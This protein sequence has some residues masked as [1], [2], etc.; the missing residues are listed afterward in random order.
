MSL[1]EKLRLGFLARSRREKL[2]TVLFLVV[3]AALWLV[4]F[5]DRAQAFGPKLAQVN[6]TAANQSTVLDD[7]ERIETKYETAV[8]TLSATDRPSGS[9]AY[10]TVDQIVRSSGFSDFNI[11]PPQPQRRDQLTFHPINVTIRKAD[12]LKLAELF[13]TITSRLPTVNLAE[14]VVAANDK[15]NPALLDASFKFV[16]IELNP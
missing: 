3:I 12:F 11:Q 4:F 10:Q 2:L 8:A 14:M 5:V 6:E 9:F 7:R 13:N 1:L 16:A 15:S